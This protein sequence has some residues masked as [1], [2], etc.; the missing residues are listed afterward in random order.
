MVGVIILNTIGTRFKWAKASDRANDWYVNVAYSQ[1]GALIVAIMN[2]N[3]YIMVFDSNDGTL[4][5]SRLF[6]GS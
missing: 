3:A 2:Y 1:D 4:K 5:T 6:P